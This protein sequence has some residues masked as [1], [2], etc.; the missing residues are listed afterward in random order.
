MNCH[1]RLLNVGI[2]GTLRAADADE[3]L[4]SDFDFASLQEKYASCFVLT[5]I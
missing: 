5:F 1:R 3:T 4:T 2:E